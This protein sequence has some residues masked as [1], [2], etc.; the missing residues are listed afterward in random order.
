MVKPYKQMDDEMPEP[1]EPM[2][3][4]LP[5]DIGGGKNYF[6]PGKCGHS[7]TS[8]WDFGSGRQTKMSPTVGGGRRVVKGK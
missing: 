3:P 7:F 6:T 2:R 5:Q 4:Q 8:V 1:A